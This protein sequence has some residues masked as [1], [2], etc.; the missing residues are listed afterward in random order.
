MSKEF[1]L[2]SAFNQTV[3]GLAVRKHGLQDGEEARLSFAQLAEEAQEYMDANLEGDLPGAVDACI[4]SIVFAMGILFKM[5]VTEEEFDTIFEVVMNA[6][7]T[8]KIGVKAG[9]E[10]FDAAD[11]VKPT[12]FIPPEVFIKEILSQ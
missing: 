11:A 5:G 6:N 4:D 9:R 8:K 12:D 3:L 2:V 10:G 7:M 1:R